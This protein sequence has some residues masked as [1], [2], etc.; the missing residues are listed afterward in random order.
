LRRLLILTL[1]VA[2]CASKPAEEIPLVP[3]W[4]SVPPGI[5]GALCQRLQ[6]DGIGTIGADVKIVKITQPIATSQALARLGE[7]RRNVSV[8]HRPLPIAAAGACAWKPID[9]LD[10]SRQFDSMVVELSSPVP[11]PAA[12]VAAGMVARASLGGNHPS[13]YWIEL[14]PHGGGWSVGRVLPLLF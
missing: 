1:L 4:D 10:P 8:P 13:W 9:A 3:D 11:N 12:K 14:I 2:A 7:S 5:T 6:L